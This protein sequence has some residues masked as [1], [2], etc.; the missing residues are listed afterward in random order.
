MSLLFHQ[1][2]LLLRALADP[3]QRGVWETLWAALGGGADAEDLN[4]PEVVGSEWLAKFTAAARTIARDEK[5]P[6][7]WRGRFALILEALEKEG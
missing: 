1:P 6:L 7:E 4:L 3:V 5:T 2:P